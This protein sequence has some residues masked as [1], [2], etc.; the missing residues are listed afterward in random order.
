MS[1]IISKFKSYQELLNRIQ[2][3]IDSG[4]YLEATWIAYAVIEDRVCSALEK[5]GG[6]PKDK[7][8]KPLRM[9]GLKLEALSHRMN[10]N[11]SLRKYLEKDEIVDRVIHWK[12]KRNP[13]MH[14]LASEA[15][16]WN[17]LEQEAKI[18]ALEGKDVAW[19]LAN[20]VS[21]FRKY[22]RREDRV[23]NDSIKR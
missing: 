9:L 5:S 16:S 8:G 11:S 4:F 23:N 6:L 2:E 17:T 22:K 13:L 19:L 18:V 10:E 12:N 7:N 20:A 21:R 3:A 1:D 14:S 15:K